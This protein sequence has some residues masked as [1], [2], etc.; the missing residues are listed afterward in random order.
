MS[1]IYRF[2]ISKGS[3]APGWAGCKHLPI[4][5]WPAEPATEALPGVGTLQAVARHVDYAL[6]RRA[7]LRDFRR[8]GLTRLDVCD[9]HPDLIRAARN[10]GEGAGRECPVCAGTDLRLVSYVYGDALKAA[11]GRCIS[12][13]GEL[14]K[15]GAS[16]DE[17][18]C[19]V[20]EVCPD[21]RWNHLHRRL[22]LGRRHAG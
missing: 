4:P 7:V 1:S 10:V 19:Y 16:I 22:L 3:I 18:A 12:F 21:C 9:A 2:D 5:S 20:V 8:G 15:L 13:P 6:A 11:N 14:E 17:F